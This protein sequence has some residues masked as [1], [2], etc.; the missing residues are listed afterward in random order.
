[1]L[2]LLWLNTMVFRLQHLTLGEETGTTAFLQGFNSE[3]AKEI[4]HVTGGTKTTTKSL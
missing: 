4:L 1:M 3:S 2:Q